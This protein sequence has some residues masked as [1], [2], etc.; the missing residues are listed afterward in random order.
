[1]TTR[2]LAVSPG[3]HAGLVLRGGAAVREG[4]A[5]RG[6]GARAGAQCFEQAALRRLGLEVVSP[7]ATC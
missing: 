7:A 4:A 6:A 3:V 1:V 5:A 2:L